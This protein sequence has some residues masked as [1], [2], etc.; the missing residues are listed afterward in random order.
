[1]LNAK[2]INEK[3][4]DLDDIDLS[5]KTR[6][7]HM[8]S[9][10]RTWQLVSIGHNRTKKSSFNDNHCQSPCLGKPVKILQVAQNICKC[11]TV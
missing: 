6:Y 2:Q 11:K 9:Y 1:M 7:G 4:K 10:D 3:G 8:M 5:A